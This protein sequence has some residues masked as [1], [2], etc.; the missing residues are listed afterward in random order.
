M[1]KKILLGLSVLG[2]SAAFWAC[3]DGS[4]EA[5]NSD[6]DV[7]L[8]N[9]GEFNPEAM[10]TLV[11][12]ATEACTADPECAAKMESAVDVPPPEQAPADSGAT[13][14]SSGAADT[15]ANSSPSTTPTSSPAGTSSSGTSPNTNP[16]VS[17]SSTAPNTNPTVSSSSTQQQQTQSSSSQ[18]Q[19]QPSSASQSSASSGG[20][21]SATGGETTKDLVSSYDLNGG[22]VS[23][24]AGT[25]IFTCSGSEPVPSKVRCLGGG[26]AE[27][28]G[29]SISIKQYEFTE[30][31]G[32]GES[33]PVK[34]TTTVKCAASNW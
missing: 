23:I 1:N 17:S 8:V 6:D 12:G 34:I 16:T 30:V 26:E 14:G 13:P 10:R 31:V 29:T 5:L 22:S 7:A 27:V 11:S 25:Y 2:M 18:Q 3:G 4:I 19:T 28:C 9:Y 15:P 32:C 20:N 33:K 24:D 21:C